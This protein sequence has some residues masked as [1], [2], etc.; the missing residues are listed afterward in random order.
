MV[1]LRSIF[2]WDTLVMVKM[3]SSPSGPM[4]V[5][6]GNTLNHEGNASRG[7]IGENRVRLSEVQG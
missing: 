6:S 5:H 3:R 4:R 2:L 7:K 1:I